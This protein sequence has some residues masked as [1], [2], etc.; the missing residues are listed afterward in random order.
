VPS[1]ELT[2][3]LEVHDP[4]S[5][6]RNG[7]LGHHQHVTEPVVEP[8]GHLAGQLEVLALVVAHRDPRGV[9]E[10]DVGGHEHGVGEQAHPDG[11]LALALVLELGHAPQLAHGGDAL[12]QPGH[13]GVLDHVALDEQGAPVGVEAGGQQ[14]EG[15]VV[16]PGPQQR[17]VDVQGQGV[18]VDHAVE[19]VVVPLVVDPVADGSQVVPQVEVAAGLDTGEDACHEW[20][21]VRRGREGSVP[22]CGS[23]GP[24]TER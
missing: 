12:E 21:M 3:L 22:P 15:G 5:G 10:H 18:E 2:D 13:L 24:R 7:R 19:G 16:G 17:R 23:G 9:V 14:V 11:L 1:G 20:A 8:D 6:R 4:G